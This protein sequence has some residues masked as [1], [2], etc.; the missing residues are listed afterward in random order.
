MKGVDQ[1]NAESTGGSETGSCRY[2]GECGQ[3]D[4][5]LNAKLAKHLS[6]NR[7]LD[8]IDLVTELGLAPV[9]PEPVFNELCLLADDNIQV[10]LDAGADHTSWLV[11]IIG[12]KIG[13]TAKE[14]KPQWRPT[15]D[16]ESDRPS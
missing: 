4:R 6:G 7:I 11:A 12:T 10:P 16:Q 14:T 15:D 2:V 3:L 1:P 5:L 8:L 9:D 13:P